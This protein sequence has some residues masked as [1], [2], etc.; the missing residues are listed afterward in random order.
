LLQRCIKVWK[1][2]E[3]A[4]KE[5]FFPQEH[6]PGELCQSDFTHLTE[7]GITIQ[8]EPFSYLLYHFVLT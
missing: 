4:E 7:L 3:G 8:K 5:V 2:L 6:H 1:A